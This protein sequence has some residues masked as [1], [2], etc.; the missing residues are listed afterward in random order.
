MGSGIAQV[1]AV[2]GHPVVLQDLDE[3]A[4]TRARAGIEKALARETEKGRLTRSAAEA[5]R[6][7]V[8]YVV[9]G[10]V[11]G[12]ASCQLVIEAIVERLGPKRESFAALERVVAPDAM[13][14]TNTSALS[15]TAIAAACQRPERVV[16]LHFFNPAPMMPLVEVVPRARDAGRPGRC[17]LRSGATLGQDHRRRRGYPGLHREP[18]RPTLLRRGA[19]DP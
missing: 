16:G 9:G 3:G 5:A 6:G 2:A 7:R 1:A 17:R 11:S 18:D 14:A 13:L 8:R 4:I 19:P 15:I 10:D 12:F